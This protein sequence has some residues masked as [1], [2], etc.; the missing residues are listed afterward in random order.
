MSAPDFFFAVNAMF[1]H[2]H[3]RH[4]KDALVDYWRGMAREYYRPRCERWRQGG[5]SAIAAD[6]QTYFEQEPQADVAVTETTTYVELNIRVCP[7]IK[8]LRDRGRDI[9]P[10]Y[11]EHCDHTCGEMA[12]QSGFTFEREGGMGSCRQRFARGGAAEEAR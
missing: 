5:L 7:A 4:G 10:Y 1:R 11:C 6:W 9:V 3:D 2:V 8:H 12:G